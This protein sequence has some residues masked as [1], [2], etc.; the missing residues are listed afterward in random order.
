[1]NSKERVRITMAHE[2]ADRIPINFRATDQIVQRLSKSFCSDYFGI[3]NYYQVDFREVIPP[4]VGPVFE[5]TSDGS[6]MD[7]WGVG[8]KELV[9]DTGR[10]VMISVNPLRDAQTPEDV[11]NH[12]WPKADWFDFS[13]IKRMCR[14]F[15]EYAI[16]TPGLHIEGYHGVFHILTY[17]FGMEKAML[18]LVVNPEPLKVAIREIMDFFKSYYERLFEAGEG[19]I[20]FLF[21]K[22]DFGAQNNLLISKE[23]FREFFFP[24]IKDLSDLAASYGGKII[25]HSCGSIMKLIPDFVEAGAAV[26]DPIQVTAK[27]MDIKELKSRFGD[28]LVFHGGIDVQRLMPFGSPMEIR[29]TTKATIEVLGKGGGYFFSPSHRFQPDTP[30]ENIKA[31]YDAVFEYGTYG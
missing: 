4:Y 20:D 2:E 29:E 14:D 30:I 10:D 16:S 17:L 1:M 12:S 26:L 6:E 9:T 5:K 25:L 19:N 28:A 15:R 13:Q 8:R 3:L 7:M 18:D 11:K 27:D 22:D 23:M 31:L 21:Y 24:N